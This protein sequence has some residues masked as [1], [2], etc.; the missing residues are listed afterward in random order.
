MALTELIIEAGQGLGEA[1]APE[2]ERIAEALRTDRVLGVLGEAEVGKTEAIRQA[3]RSRPAETNLLVLD[4]DGAAGKEQV[5]F[6]ILKQIAAAFLGAPQFSILSVGTLVP[7]SVQSERV[8]L[9]R[10]IG[11]DGLDEALREWPSGTFPLEKALAALDAYAREHESILWVDHLEAPAL[12]PRHPLDVDGLLWG[13]RATAQQRERLSLI[14]SARSAFDTELL[15]RD[16]AFYQQGRWLEI[17]NPTPPVWAEVGGRLEVDGD[18]TAELFE[19]TRGHPGTMLRALPL[20]AGTPRQ[21]DGAAEIIRDLASSSFPL[22][23]RANQHARSLHRL[24][25]QVLLQVAMG[26]RPYAAA[27]KGASPPQEIRKVLGRLHLAGLIRHDPGTWSVVDPLVGA[28]LRGEVHPA[29]AE[30]L[31]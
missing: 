6:L 16:R 28:V 9:A 15:G 5:A 3:L 24:G 31:P 23:A 8:E 26:R 7:A 18:L 21:R 10:L 2:V 12:T 20:A 17:D 13:L 25:S 14:L 27:Q 19:L 4:L 11:V 1:R 22:A 29:V 30:D